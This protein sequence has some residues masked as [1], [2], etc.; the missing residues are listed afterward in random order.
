MQEGKSGLQETLLAAVT[1]LWSAGLVLDGERRR[2]RH[3]DGRVF[4]RGEDGR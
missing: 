2:I 4:I 1:D 3:F